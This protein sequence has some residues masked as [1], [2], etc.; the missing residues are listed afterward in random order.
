MKV[1]KEALAKIKKR[2]VQLSREEIEAS[3]VVLLAVR[4]ELV[5]SFYN[6]AE[7]RLR[8]LYDEYAFMMLKLDKVIQLLRRILEKPTTASSQKPKHEEIE[9]NLSK[10]QPNLAQALRLLLQSAKMLREFSNSMPSYYLRVLI[11]NINDQID[12]VIKFLGD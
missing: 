6:I 1:L 11:K 12:K 4:E 7:R 8:E 9:E 2:S 10:L 5:E 3:Y